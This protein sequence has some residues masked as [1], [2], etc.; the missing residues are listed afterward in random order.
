MKGRSAKR[1]KRLP[2]PGGDSRGVALIMVLWVIAIL[3][4]VVTEFSF[5]MRTEVNITRNFQ[6]EL[7]LYAM[8]EGG[9][10]RAVA[11]L[12]YKH[13]S[14]I[15]QWRK[16]FKIEE[17]PPEQKEW[18]TDGRDYSLTFQKGECAIRIMGEAGKMNI[19]A[20]SEGTLRRVVK[21]LGLDEE[22]QG[23]VVDSI[24]DWRD[25]DDLYRLNG[26]ENE[27][28]RGLPEPY[29]CKNG[30]LDSV[31]EL[32]L[33]RGV[34]PEIFF[35]KRREKAEE[36]EDT[37]PMG[38]KD[39]FSIYATGE[40]IDINSAA[41]PVLKVVLGI[42]SAVA[43]QII[44]AREEKGFESQ[45]DLLQRVPELNPFIGEAGKYILFRATVPYYTVEARAKWKE[46][47]SGRGIKTI[48]KIDPKE[49]KGCKIIQWVDFFTGG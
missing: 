11:E 1:F 47:A 16:S 10:Q 28:Y 14:R 38:F 36:G 49:K 37:E 46:G 2:H 40:Q 43:Q 27:Y 23:I 45:Q 30:N 15:Q 31:E 19:N 21:N 13:D 12:V 24:L 4:L 25:P 5:S 6:E 41:L 7:Q 18:V 3:S 34:T 48:L 44:K 35:G 39:I 29:D 32:L 20:V 26:A 9:I 22:T 33:I 42:P 17:I 8:A